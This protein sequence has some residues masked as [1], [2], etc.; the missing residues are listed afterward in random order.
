M[1]KTLLLLSVVALA[2]CASPGAGKTSSQ[3]NTGSPALV[4]ETAP[5]YEYQLDIEY[6]DGATPFLRLVQVN[7]P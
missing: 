5:R 6:V 1:K 7:D 3:S 4:A 2:G